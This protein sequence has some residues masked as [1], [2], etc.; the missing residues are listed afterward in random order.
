MRYKPLLVSSLIG[1]MLVASLYASP[2]TPLAREP[3]AHT[4]PVSSIPTSP[5]SQPEVAAPIL[6]RVPSLAIEAGIEEVG[7]THDGNMAAP[8]TNSRLEWYKYGA[9]P[10]NPG[11]AVLA[12]HTGLPEQP[13]TFRQLETLKNGDAV[14]VKD[15]NGKIIPFTIIERAIYTP[16]TAPRQRIFGETSVARLAIIICTGKWLPEKKTYSHRLVVYAIRG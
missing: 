14:E 12:A 4:T 1:L 11:P 6:F 15:T 8:Q 7:L 13:T 3:V 2:S 5:T 10:G 9:F 16:E